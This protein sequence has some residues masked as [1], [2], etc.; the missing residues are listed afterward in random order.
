MSDVAFMLRQRSLLA[1]AGTLVGLTL[2]AVL[3]FVWL[4]PILLVVM[5]S[6]KSNDAFLAGPFARPTEPT[7][8]P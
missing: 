8:A 7:F 3:V 2:L 5:T 6:I 1:F 4:G